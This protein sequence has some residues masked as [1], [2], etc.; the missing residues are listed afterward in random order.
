ML[1]TILRILL[2]PTLIILSSPSVNAE[3][4]AEDKANPKEVFQHEL[5]AASQGMKDAQQKGPLDIPLLNQAVL[6][7]PK[8]YAYVPN[9]AASRFMTAI[10]NRVDENFLGLI[11][12]EGGEAN[13][14][15]A[16]AFQ[17]SG[18]I[19]DDDA[20]SW[21]VD[22]MLKSI[23]EGADETNESRASRGIPE[24]DVVGWAEPP[25]YDAVNHRL[26]WALTVSSRGAP[27][28]QPQS[29]NYNT[30]ALGRE[31]FVNLNLVTAINELEQRKPIAESLLAS[32]EFNQ[33]KRYEDFNADTDKAAGFGLAALVGGALVAK[34]FGLFALASVFIAKFG[35][36]IAIAAAALFGI[37]GKRMGKKKGTGS[38]DA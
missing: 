8:G 7:L 4:I 27:A 16:L 38:M 32:M 13:W 29:V 23:K 6:H 14:A 12:P 31:G 5:D 34:K 2:L 15:A 18:Y 3:D 19:R 24:L 35:K 30:Y 17:K 22:D 37:F 25:D 9:P 1:L 33:G 36:I 20:K 21:N 10:G 26:V 28:D 11:L